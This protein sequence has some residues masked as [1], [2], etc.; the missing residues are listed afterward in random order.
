MRR[1]VISIPSNIAEG[2]GRS[3]DKELLRFLD[4]AKNSVCELDTQ[5]EIAKQLGYL[6]PNEFTIIFNLLDE[7]S[8]MLTGLRRSKSQNS[9]LKT[10]L[11]KQL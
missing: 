9:S 2:H 10:Q 4:I 7:T 6:S 1:S 11:Q 3:S 5:I 8:P